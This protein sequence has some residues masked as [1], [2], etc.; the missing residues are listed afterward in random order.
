MNKVYIVMMFRN[1][2]SK[3]IFVILA[4]LL[5]LGGLG[6]DVELVK[7]FGV[8]VGI[9]ILT[10]IWLQKRKILFPPFIILYSLFLILFLLNT[11]VISVDTEKS[12]GV[13]SLFLSG[14]LFWVVS[15]N[16][17]KEFT[18]YFD[19]LIIVLGLVFAGLYF[20]NNLFADPN[21]VSPWSLYLN[22]SA[23]RNHNNLGDLWAIV[24]TVVIYYLFKNPKNILFWLFT[25]LGS[26]LLYVSQSRAALVSLAA[27]VLYLAKEKGWIGKYKAIMSL[28][29]A[30][31]IGLFL[32]I[33]T[34]KT[35][36]FTRQYYVQGLLGFIHNPQGV[37]VGNFDIISRNPDNHILGLSH[38]SS[39]AHNIVLEMM[40]G[41]GI[42]GFVFVWWIIKVLREAWEDKDKRNL[43]YRA[44]FIALF[45]NFFFHSSYFI[46]TMLWLGFGSLGLS[47]K[48]EKR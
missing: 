40:S 47:Q 2:L 44:V 18:L 30:I 26:N 21:F 34:Q 14:G 9:L 37:G 45:V 48:T 11:F 36:L 1:S 38:F 32:I 27:G 28:F 16:L 31:S 39:V 10:L 19:K 8:L 7:Y 17:K 6:I 25:V 46:P 20:Y 35:T 13:F 33:G 4:V 23:Y 3:I 42:L 41:M 22:Y 5:F 24:L 29:I 12:L 15:Y 43:V